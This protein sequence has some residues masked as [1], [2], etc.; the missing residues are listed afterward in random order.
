MLNASWGLFNNY[1]QTQ[2]CTAKS[3]SLRFAYTSSDL[4]WDLIVAS[5]HVQIDKCRSLR[6]N[7]RTHGFLPYVGLINEGQYILYIYHLFL[8]SV[9]IWCDIF[10]LKNT[11]LNTYMQ[12]LCECVK[13]DCETDCD[14]RGLQL[15][16]CLGHQI[17]QGWHW[18]TWLLT[19]NQHMTWW[20]EN[21]TLWYHLS[22]KHR[23]YFF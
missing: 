23:Y 22:K 14:A 6:G 15:R 20:E 21:I 9:F 3:R 1:F 19:T 13:I 16:S 12:F 5:A 4:K 10:D 11:V 18:R 2:H 17:T 7:G 8:S